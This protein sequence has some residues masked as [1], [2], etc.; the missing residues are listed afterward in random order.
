MPNNKEKKKRTTEMATSMETEVEEKV[1]I[2]TATT[3]IG[4]VVMEDAPTSNK[5]KKKKTKLKTK[6]RMK[7]NKTTVVV[8]M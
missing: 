1:N 4:D 8:S 2:T 7:I 6:T 3:K 5:E